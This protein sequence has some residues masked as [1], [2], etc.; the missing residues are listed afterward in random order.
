MDAVWKSKKKLGDFPPAGFM[1]LLQSIPSI[2]EL[3]IC[4]LDVNPLMKTE[5][6]YAISTKPK[7]MKLFYDS[8]VGS[9]KVNFVDENNVFVGYDLDRQ[10]CENADWFIS[11]D[12]E[13]TP[14][15]I[16]N[17]LESELEGYVFDPEFF[18]EKVFGE[19]C[20]GKF[21]IFRIVKGKDEK[22]IHLF[23]VQNGWYWH[24]FILK[25]DGVVI[26]KDSI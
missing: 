5:N 20:D 6:T 1:F 24:G 13:S 2:E 7:N 14:P 10:C 22:F 21:A 11:N 15:D 18:E 3:S 4:V 9:S 26:K 8:P 25:I 19:D 23:N 12:K 16:L 17:K